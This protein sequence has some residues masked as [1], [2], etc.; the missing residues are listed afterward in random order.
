VVDVLLIASTLPAVASSTYTAYRGMQALVIFTGCT[1]TLRFES[2]KLEPLVIVD[3]HATVNTYA[4]LVLTARH[5]WEI[6]W[7]PHE[8]Q[9]LSGHFLC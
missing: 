9:L 8:I 3:Q 1:V 2:M 4:S 5:A 6:E 7:P